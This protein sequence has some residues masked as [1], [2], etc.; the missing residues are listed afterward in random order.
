[1]S[2]REFITWQAWIEA[3]WNQPSRTDYYLMSLRAEVRS[4][5]HTLFG[6]HGTSANIKLEDLR[7]RFR[8]QED[9]K[10][11]TKEEAVASAKARWS[12]FVGGKFTTVQS[13]PREPEYSLDL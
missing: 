8:S 10:L 5:P 4:L 6:K 11:Q 3:E 1:M 12:A 9:K 2:H 7:L 13:S